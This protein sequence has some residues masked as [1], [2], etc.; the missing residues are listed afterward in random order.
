MSRVVTARVPGMVGQRADRREVRREL[1]VQ[2][3]EES[4][5]RIGGDGGRVLGVDQDE[6]IGVRDQSMSGE[7]LGRVHDHHARA[8]PGGGEPLGVRSAVRGAIE[9]EPGRR[10]VDLDHS[11]SVRSTGPSRA[12][13]A[14]TFDASPR[15]TVTAS[16]GAM[17]TAATRAMS[18]A[19]TCASC[20]E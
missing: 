15:M 2:P 18:S 1:L 19:V 9:Y 5:G 10:G 13:D 16:D 14:W 7:R 6:F 4:F 8:Q 3:E 12:S 17:Y 20:A 11:M